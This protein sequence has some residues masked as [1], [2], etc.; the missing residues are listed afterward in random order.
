[1]LHGTQRQKKLGDDGGC[2]AAAL[3]SVRKWGGVLEHPEA[4]YAFAHH[5]LATPAWRAGWQYAGDGFG[6]RVCCVAQGNYGHRARKLTW[7]YA[8][9]AKLPALDWSIPSAMKRLE[10]SF[11][12][13]AEAEDRRRFRR[14]PKG[15]SKELRDAHN[16]Y[17]RR[18][19]EFTGLMWCA[20]ERMNKRERAATPP[21][22]R[23]LLLT[24]ARSCRT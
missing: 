17:L 16:A 12:S 10:E 9:G 3:A 11:H 22:F 6:G 14:L 15:A 23:D 21:A 18:Q 20:L 19:E 8:V 5:G 24:I 4:S 1:M 7:L 2:F 13:K